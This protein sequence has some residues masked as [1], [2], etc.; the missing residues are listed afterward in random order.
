MCAEEPR[1]GGGQLHPWLQQ[2]LHCRQRTQRPEDG[3][4]FWGVLGRCSGGAGPV[5]WGGLGRCS[6][7]GWA[8]AGLNKERVLTPPAEGGRAWLICEGFQ[9]I[10]R[11]QADALLALGVSQDFK[12]GARSVS[13]GRR[14]RVS[15]A[16]PGLVFRTASCVRCGGCICRRVDRP[17]PTDQPGAPTSD[18]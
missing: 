8:G 7:A 5:F 2:G 14:S 10:L 16:D 13:P 15:P 17:T 9:F 12:V 11:A 1:C 4:V 6:G 18:W 3:S